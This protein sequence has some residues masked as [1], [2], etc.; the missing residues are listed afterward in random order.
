MLHV[1]KKIFDYIS[2]FQHYFNSIKTNKNK[3]IN[4]LPRSRAARYQKEFLFNPDAEH[5][6]I[7]LI[8]IVKTRLF[9]DI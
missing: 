2:L 5:Q 3:C 1:N 4:E 9:F 6:G 8:K 7:R